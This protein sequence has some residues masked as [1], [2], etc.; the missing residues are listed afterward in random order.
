MPNWEC[1]LIL[2]ATT[3]AFVIIPASA[4]ILSEFMSGEIYAVN[5]NPIDL[6][7]VKKIRIKY[8]QPFLEG[9][10][11]PSDIFHYVSYVIFA[12][13]PSTGQYMFWVVL[14]DVRF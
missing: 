8:D 3:V 12:V 1:E 11:L 5:C 13:T 14:R 6:V 9:L 7:V 10:N 4:W 2:E